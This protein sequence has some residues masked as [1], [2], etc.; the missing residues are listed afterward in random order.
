MLKTTLK[1]LGLAAMLALPVA[2]TSCAPIEPVVVSVHTKQFN[3]AQFHKLFDALGKQYPLTRDLRVEIKTLPGNYLGLTSRSGER[4][5]IEIEGSQGQQ[6][7]IDTLVHE[8]AHA[9]VWD[10]HGDDHG[11]LWG[12]AWAKA[13]RVYLETLLNDTP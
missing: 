10:T 9:M 11:A 12:V 3:Q 6:G 13:Y 5:L 2:C 4:L 7:I 1:S 8:W